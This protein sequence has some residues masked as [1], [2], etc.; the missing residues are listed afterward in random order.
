MFI[1]AFCP[2]TDGQSNGANCGICPSGAPVCSKI[3]N[4]REGSC[5][6]RAGVDIEELV[7]TRKGSAAP[8]MFAS[9]PDKPS[10][11]ILSAWLSYMNFLFKKSLVFGFFFNLSISVFVEENAAFVID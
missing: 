6:E 9:S 4:K 10:Q 2:W 3:G 11:P 8:L 1:P 7:M 5:T